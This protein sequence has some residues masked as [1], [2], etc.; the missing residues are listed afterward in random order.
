MVLLRIVN[1]SSV[2]GIFSGM[3]NRER[4]FCGEICSI[5]G[6]GKETG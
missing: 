1:F 6:I 2:G 4:E 3:K 5:V